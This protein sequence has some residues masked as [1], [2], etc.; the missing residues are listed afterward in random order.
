[1]I[2]FVSIKMRSWALDRKKK[3]PL[4]P[5]C[6]YCELKSGSILLFFPWQQCHRYETDSHLCVTNMTDIQCVYIHTNISI[7]PVFWERQWDHFI[8]LKKRDI[9][10]LFPFA[11]AFSD[12]Y[13]VKAV[14]TDKFPTFSL[15]LLQHCILHCSHLQLFSP[16]LAHGEILDA[17]VQ[18]G[19]VG[20]R[21]V[22]NELMSDGE[23][24]SQMSHMSF[25]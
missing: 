14:W 24:N 6:L 10:L 22:L 19:L 17:G 23:E 16:L 9:P 12:S 18:Q 5:S 11:W 21:G 13:H 25:K 15:P 3:N 2:N 1:M 7:L 4:L 20:D 8:A